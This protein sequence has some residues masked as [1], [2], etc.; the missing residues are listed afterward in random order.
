MSVSHSLPTLRQDGSELSRQVL[1]AG[2]V[3]AGGAASPLTPVLTSAGD[4]FLANDC[5][6]FLET[7][8]LS[9]DSLSPGQ[10]VTLSQHRVGMF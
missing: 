5:Y 1:P 4:A 8:L 7:T 2:R 9:S 3:G 10:G 6:R